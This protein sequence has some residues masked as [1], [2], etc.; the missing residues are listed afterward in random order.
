MIVLNTE[1]TPVWETLSPEEKKAILFQRQK[2]TLAMFLQKGA[3]SQA[4]H[5][6][7]LGDLIVKMGIED[8]AL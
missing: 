1:Q 2:E 3:I 4:Q 5:D 7:S 6:K 8:L